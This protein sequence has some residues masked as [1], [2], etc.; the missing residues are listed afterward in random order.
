MTDE[1]RP[2]VESRS[3]AVMDCISALQIYLM[4]RMRNKEGVAGGLRRLGVDEAAFDAAK[5]ML[6][7]ARLDHEDPDMA[8]E[9]S[10]DLYRRFLGAP[11]RVEPAPEDHAPNAMKM[12]Y[13]LPVWPDLELELRMSNEHTLCGIRF[14]RAGEPKARRLRLEEVIPWRV[15]EDDIPCNCSEAVVVDG[16]GTWTDYCCTL[17]EPGSPEYLW[18]FDY[19]LLQKVIPW[20]DLNIDKKEAAYPSLESVLGLEEPETPR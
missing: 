9:C 7:R 6:A 15:V 8:D 20:K 11:Q 1:R 4:S 10:A 2:L 19:G 17:L 3:G 5:E 13:S 12:F 14:V 16:F 18:A